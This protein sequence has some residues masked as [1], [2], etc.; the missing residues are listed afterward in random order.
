MMTGIAAALVAVGLWVAPG[1]AAPPRWRLDA[2]EGDGQRVLEEAARFAAAGDDAPTTTLLTERIYTLDEAH[3][4]VLTVR[5]VYRVER[6]G[7]ERRESLSARWVAWREARPE[8][9]ARVVGPDGQVRSLDPSTLAEQGAGPAGDMVYSDAREIAAPLP[10]VRPGAVVETR[11]VRRSTAPIDPAGFSVVE[12]VGTMGS[13]GGHFRWVFDAPAGLGL[14]HVVVGGKLPVEVRTRGGRRRIVVDRAP[15]PAAPFETWL[16]PEGP[17]LPRLGVTTVPSWNASARAYARIVEQ[18][19]ASPGV[20][21]AVA[22]LVDGLPR[23]GTP[24][25]DVVS[26]VGAVA[27][28]LHARTRYT[29][30]ELG[31]AALVPATPAE[32][33]ERGYGDCK[34][35]AA[36]MAAALRALGHDAHLALLRRGLGADVLPAVPG[37]GVFDHAILY[38]DGE[39]PVWLDLTERYARPGELPSD[40][41][42]RHALVV[43]PETHGLVRTPSVL[44]GANLIEEVRTYRLPPVGRARVE[45]RYRVRGLAAWNLR[46]GHAEW[47]DEQ[48]DEWVRSFV[49]D[50]YLSTKYRLE[51]RGPVDGGDSRRSSWSRTRPARSPKRAS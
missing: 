10:S 6:A 33:L 36:T 11:V 24:G 43:R 25:A 7:P 48:W 49:P 35:L 40:V 2:F 37:I 20:A 32:T 41:Q 50:Q 8:L 13:P 47:T 31:T 38:V 1:A 30:V 23:A 4:P 26:A 27:E 29:G 22:P 14:R 45:E 28:R 5:R 39:A 19:I 12:Y 16:R 18:R 42:G 9:K 51:R 17:P 46:R 34:D 21:E 44:A 3:L 15:G